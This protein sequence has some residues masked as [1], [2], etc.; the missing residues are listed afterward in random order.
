MSG[1]ILL[2]HAVKHL[3]G[4]AAT[5]IQPSTRAVPAGTC[6]LMY[7]RCSQTGVFDFSLDD[8][9]VKPSSLE[10]HFRWLSKNAECVPLPE[11]LLTGLS[12]ARSKPVVVL[13]FD[14][15]FANFRHAALPLLQ[16]YGLPATLFVVTAYVD[17][18]EPY[19]FDRWGSKNVSRVP[20]DAWQPIT[21]KE[22]EECL[23][24]GLISIGSHSHRH[25]N[26]KDATEDQLAEEAGLSRETLA[27]RLGPEHA[28][29]YA[30]PYGSSRLGHVNPSYVKAVRG[31]G[32]QL[33]VTTDLGLAQASDPPFLIPRVEV[34][35]YDTP[36]LL[37][38]KARGNLWPQR[39]CDR[40]RRASRG[41]AA[42]KTLIPSI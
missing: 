35:G 14:D 41:S 30:Y 18:P 39:I 8:W 32:Y 31:G 34:H 6:V 3:A 16:R 27:N 1:T 21:W 20:P 11:V 4:L 24:T 9:N 15:G 40:F 36:R 5:M 19:P 17:S 23:D 22:I 7:H 2:K 33:A 10:D 37:E 29:L 26:G 38:E 42:C 28:R 25:L 12:E 13:T